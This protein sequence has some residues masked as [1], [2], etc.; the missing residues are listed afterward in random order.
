MCVMGNFSAYLV[1]KVYTHPLD[2]VAGK[3][4]LHFHL[5]VQASIVVPCTV[6]DTTLAIGVDLQSEV[7]ILESLE[8]SS[9]GLIVVKFQGSLMSGEIA[10]CI[11][12][13]RNARKDLRQIAVVLKLL[14]TDVQLN[15]MAAFQQILAKCIQIVRNQ[16]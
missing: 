1:R 15:I 11:L 6:H 12:N 2:N 13:C 7:A 8:E 16:L 5:A 3:T 10:E 14:Y 9:V 4:R